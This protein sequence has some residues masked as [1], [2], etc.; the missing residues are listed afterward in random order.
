MAKGDKEQYSLDIYGE[1]YS[2]TVRQLMFM[3]ITLSV[4]ATGSRP[5]TLNTFAT[6][7]LASSGRSE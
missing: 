2:T 5:V 6:F 3:Q 1:R 4:H 7:V